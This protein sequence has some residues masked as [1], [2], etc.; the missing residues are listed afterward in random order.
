LAISIIWVD[1]CIGTRY[2]G[3]IDFPLCKTKAMKMRNPIQN[4]AQR[5]G[6]IV[7]LKKH[8]LDELNDMKSY[9]EDL[10]GK[11]DCMDPCA[12]SSDER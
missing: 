12:D 6:V 10:G 3:N 4:Q 9:N 11:S 8:N 5:K 7:L 1:P 2:G